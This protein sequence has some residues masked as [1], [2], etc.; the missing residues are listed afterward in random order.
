[1]S[2]KSKIVSSLVAAIMT[3]IIIAAVDSA[4]GNEKETHPPHIQ[5][6]K[7]CLQTVLAC[8]SGPTI[9][10]IGVLFYEYEKLVATQRVVDYV[11]QVEANEAAASLAVKSSN[12][13]NFSLPSSCDGKVIPA[14]IVMRESGCDYG[15]VNYDGCGGTN[16]YGM[17]QIAGFHWNG[18]SCSDLNWSIPA[19]QDEC[20]RRL[21]DNGNNLA[22]WAF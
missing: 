21:S 18:G 9:E 8:S 5:Q 7:L 2:N 15:A 11:K 4:V 10:E 6:P 3:F 12:R 13:N 14:Y 1:M 20:A 17:Y 19:D 22:P 16:C